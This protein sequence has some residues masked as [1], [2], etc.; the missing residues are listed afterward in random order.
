MWEELD[1]ATI[2][3]FDGKFKKGDIYGNQEIEPILLEFNRIGRDCPRPNPT[4]YCYNRW[5]VNMSRPRNLFEYVGRGR[6]KYLGYGAKF[7]GETVNAVRHNG[8]L[9][10]VVGTW[11]NGE[12]SFENGYDSFAAWV[13]AT[14][15][16]RN[17]RKFKD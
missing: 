4:A 3:A 7:T 12:F 9:E 8:G 1:E 10:R 6:F 2:K 16:M 14:Q 13:R 11:K 5:N 15:R 17:S